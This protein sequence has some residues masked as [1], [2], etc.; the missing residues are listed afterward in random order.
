VRSCAICNDFEQQIA[1]QAYAEQMQHR[2][3]GLPS[4]Q[5]E[6]DLPSRADVRINDTAAVIVAESDRA[7]LVPMRWSFPPARPGSGPV[8][9]F[10][11]EGRRFVNAR[12]CLVPASAF[13]EFTTSEDPKQKRKDKWRFARL[14][15]AWMALAGL[16]RPAEGNQ[17]ATF[18]LLTCD[19][20]PDI[21][22]IHKR[23]II[24]LEPDC[25]RAWLELSRPEAD[26][27]TPTPPGTLK[28]GKA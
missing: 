28:I 21:Q 4:V 3:W 2:A 27:L 16:W 25:W 11:S 5:S 19:A 20:G 8:F 9:N 23:Q 15:G 26:L 7:E 12:R 13:Y 18:T 14:D 17:P 10:R 24:P 22:P 1:Y 6:L